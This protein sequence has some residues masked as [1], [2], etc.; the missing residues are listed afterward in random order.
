MTA[1]M[2]SR[3][4]I[5]RS[6]LV[7]GALALFGAPVATAEA[8]TSTNWSGYVAHGVK[9]RSASALWTQ[10]TLTC[11]PGT[12]SYSAAW[13]GLGGYNLSSKALEQIGT[14]ADCTGSGRQVSTA[15]YELVPAPSRG[16]GMIV[17]PGDVMAG[18]VSVVG[19]KVTLMLTDRTRHKTYTKTV[20]VS[21]VDV[22]SADWIVEAP[23]QCTGN[24]FQCQPLTLAN[25]GTQTFA[26]ANAQTAKGQT[27][28]IASALWRTEVITLNP[29]SNGTRNASNGA[30]EGESSPSA[31]TSAGT[32]F[33][34][35]Y[36]PITA[37]PGPP[38]ATSY[39]SSRTAGL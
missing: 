17:R 14:E 5:L 13:V 16:L 15:W 2:V 8:S 4:L 11:T 19:N 29:G 3:S 30:S 12:Q 31:L 1:V 20:S 36:T 37:A 21:T 35:T 27:G 26:R 28:A 18:H 25:Y 32:G 23:S 9:F 38:T 10:P 24:G 34:L 7:A 39:L 22:T 6:V 33:T